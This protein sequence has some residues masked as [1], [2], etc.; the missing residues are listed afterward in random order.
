[1]PQKQRVLTGN[2]MPGMIIAEDIYSLN[3]QM[4]VAKGNIVTEKLIVRLGFY[5]IKSVAVKV[6]EKAIEEVIPQA[7]QSTYSERIRKSKTFQKF[8]RDFSN[9][10]TIFKELIG[11]L[12]NKQ[13]T[14]E[15]VLEMTGYATDLFE[16]I[17]NNLE[18][19]DM[20]HNMREN[21]DS[22]YA[23]SINVALISSV[24]GRWMGFKKEDIS[25][26]TMSGLFHDIG[27]IMIPKDIL[28]K[29][30]KLDE[31]EYTIIKTHTMQGYNILKSMELDERVA[32]SALMHHERCDGSGY[33]IGIESGQI[34]DFA[35]IVAIADVYDAMTSSRLYRA[36]ICPFK[37]ISIFEQ[38][39]LALY[40]AQFLTVFLKKI[41]NTYLQN[42]VRLSD[43]RTGTVILINNLALSRPVVQLDNGGYIDLYRHPDTA[44]DAII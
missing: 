4:I 20:L 13:L 22:T 28:N 6:E 39:G 2:L 42:S 44:I 34:N 14:E 11:D 37:V 8:E 33:P 41:V 40:D 43:G 7:A 32:C 16:S 5:S 15:A 10:T 30:A 9:T 21:D 36:P 27:K 17:E 19:F 26:L 35:K 1:M 18:V 31:Q 29:P 12:V 3:G 38:E 24:I 25:I 23:H